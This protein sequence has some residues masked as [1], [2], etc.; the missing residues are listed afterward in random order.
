M[1]ESFSSPISSWQLMH[2]LIL[3]I[4]ARA[5]FITPVWQVSQVT[6]ISSVWILCGKSI[7]CTGL[8]RMP[9][10]SF[11][12]DSKLGCAVVKTAELHRFPA[13]GSL[14]R[15]VY[16]GTFACCTQPIV[17]TA[18]NNRNVIDARCCD[19]RLERV[20]TV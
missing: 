3:G 18:I 16:P 20:V 8:G 15:L 6:P 19:L 13:Y 11:A 12:A 10:K 4:P 7:G 1:R 2:I 5:P 14:A 17:S 9:R